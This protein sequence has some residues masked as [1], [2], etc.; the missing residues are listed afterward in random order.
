MS[1]SE[2]WTVK[3][4]L[5]WT[6]DFFTKKGL[7]TPRLEAEIL[8]A[9]RESFVLDANP[10]ITVEVNPGTIDKRKVD[11]YA[12]NGVNRVSVGLQSASDRLLKRVGRP[13]TLQDF[14]ACVALLRGRIHN[15]SAD[16]MLGLPEQRIQDVADTLDKVLPLKLNHLSVYALTVEPGTKLAG[17]TP[18]DDL[19]ADM[20]DYAAS[21]LARAGYA[22]YEVSNFCRDGFFSRHNQKYWNMDDYAGYGVSAHAYLGGKRFFHTSD[23]DAYLA[24]ENRVTQEARKPEDDRTEYIM[25][26]LRTATGL[27]LAR[28]RAKFC[29]DL[30]DG[31]AREIA[32][33]TAHGLIVADGDTL[34]LTDKGFYV[35]NQVIL[36]L[37]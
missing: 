21:A 33:L 12:D 10:E 27:D 1:Q 2:I 20:Y 35:M 16:L 4:L 7:E 29:S 5:E 18:D 6:T 24:G 23:I 13:H 25:L 34:K 37:I 32:D 8:L 14:Y 3:R 15:V 30:A 28:Y 36:R 17:Y 9:V 26:A 11:E 31:K 22:R 19:T